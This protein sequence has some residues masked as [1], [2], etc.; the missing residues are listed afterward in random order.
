MGHDDLQQPVTPSDSNRLLGVSC[1]DEKNLE[2]PLGRQERAQRISVPCSGLKYFA[3]RESGF[4]PPKGCQWG[5]R[6][7]GSTCRIT[8]TRMTRPT[9]PA[10]GD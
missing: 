3:R 6:K 7:G 2:R 4:E 1:P 10:F 5:S 8:V 9:A